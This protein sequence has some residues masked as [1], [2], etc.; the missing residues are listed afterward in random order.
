MSEAMPI[1]VL[2]GRE[3][4]WDET[5]SNQIAYEDVAGIIEVRSLTRSYQRVIDQT[6]PSLGE[7]CGFTWAAKVDY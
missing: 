2:P 5:F 1:R 6:E 7:G 4:H 3:H